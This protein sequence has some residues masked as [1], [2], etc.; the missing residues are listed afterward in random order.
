LKPR[1]FY[2]DTE[3]F[4]HIHEYQPSPA[5]GEIRFIKSYKEVDFYNIFK[6]KKINIRMA[7]VR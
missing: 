5:P 1:G 3:D 4:A 2:V 7:G 6:D